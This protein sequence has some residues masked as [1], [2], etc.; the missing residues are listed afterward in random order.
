[1]IIVLPAILGFYFLYCIFCGRHTDHSIRSTGDY[2]I[3]KCKECG[4]E[5]SFRVR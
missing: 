1:M 2:E 4:N 5:Q 3:Y